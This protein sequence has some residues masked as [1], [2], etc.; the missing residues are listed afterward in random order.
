MANETFKSSLT[1]I[2]PEV[3]ADVISA[4]LP[5]KLVVTPF[6][7][8]DTTLEGTAGGT[9]K[10]PVYQYIGDAVDVA[11]GD[12]IPYAELTATTTPYTVKKVGKGFTISDEAQGA[13]TGDP[14]NE[15]TNQLIKAIASKADADGL[16]ALLTA[17][18]KVDASAAI[19]YEAVVTVLDKFEEEFNSAK[20]MFISPKQITELR[21]DPDFISADK[22]N[23][24]VIMTGEI[25]M[26]A[27]TRIVPTKKV[28]AKSGKYN[29]PIVKIETDAETEDET[30]AL[31]LFMKK[32]LEVETGRDMDHKMT[33]VNADQHY[34]MALTNDDKVVIGQFTATP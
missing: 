3:M 17:S 23:N 16:D 34:V 31:T 29:C 5:S 9:V 30:P 26:I 4:K 1:N 13:A 22:Y 25:G 27:N 33:K 12:P 6:A 7:K 2:I 28:V 18:R 11:E 14:I 8:V 21:L 20:V 19:S 24:A 10:I 32:E 15:G